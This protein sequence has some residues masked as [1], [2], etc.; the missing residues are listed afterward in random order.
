[1]S[2][3]R[4][5]KLEVY[6]SQSVARDYDQRW[7]GAV[8]A[9]RDAR[10]AHA[11]K[12]ALQCIETQTGETALS[13]LDI[14]CGTGRFSQ[15]W[16]DRDLHVIGADLA[17]PM[18]AEA[19]LKYPQSTY[20]AADLAKLPFADDSVD[21]AIC[22]RFLHLVRDPALRVA[23]LKELNRV[24]RMGAIIDYRHGRTLRVWG[25][26]LRYRLGL[27]AAAPANPSP[28]EIRQEVAAA[29][30]KKLD[31]I[32]VHRAPLLSDKVLIPVVTAE[33]GLPKT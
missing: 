31:W 25:R 13:L 18:L 3:Q 26:H 15:L 16:N 1:M 12:K 10:K 6:R 5:T 24:S 11:L 7:A 28:R 21:V 20:L 32:P 8:G 17:L 29:G 30:W 19:Q 9:K 23:F 22:V 14:P 2:Q 33:S 4:P 27:R